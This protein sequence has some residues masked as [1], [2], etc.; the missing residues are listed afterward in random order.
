M[1]RPHPADWFDIIV[2][3]DDMVLLVEELARNACV[4][5]EADAGGPREPSRDL[6]EALSRFANLAQRF[7]AYWPV[8]EAVVRP[9]EIHDMVKRGLAGIE[10][11]AAAA[12]PVLE[13]LQSLEG[14]R[15]SLALW[16]EVLLEIEDGAL[17]FAQ[18]TAPGASVEGA[19]FVFPGEAAPALP[20]MVLG[21]RLRVGPD[22][23]V[24]AIGPPAG[25]AA[26]TQQA[27]S[28]QGKRVEIPRWLRGS[29]RQSL[30]FMLERMEAVDQAAVSARAE[31]AAIS[32]Q[33]RLGEGLGLLRHA[34]WM[35]RSIEVVASGEHFC[36]ITGW[37]DDRRRLAATMEASNARALVHFPD[38]PGG[39]QAP[40]LLRNPWWA[41]PFEVFSRALGMPARY[42]AD[43]SMLLALIVPLLFGYMFGDVGQGAVLIGAGL[44]LRNRIPVL[45]MLLAGGVSAMLF[46]LVFGSVF[47]M[48]GVLPTLW[49]RP[50][51]EPLPVLIVPLVGG[52]LL[53]VLGLAINALGAYWRGKFRHWLATDA[54]LIVVYLG[55]L[56][57]FLDARGYWIAALGAL[58]P[59]AGHLVITRRV[60]PALAAAGELLEKIVRLL[61]N[62]L[63]FVRVGAFALAHAGLSA[64]IIA[65]AE[66]ATSAPGYL[67][68][69]IV[70]NA[71]AIVVEAL[72]VSVQTTRLVLFEFFTRFFVSKGREYRPLPPPAF[73]RG[74]LHE[75]TI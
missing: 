25:L 65:L 71:I 17:D 13:T 20:S 49:V 52:G 62:T 32:A 6:Q 9:S 28:A 46:G 40:L 38:P 51:D 5:L 7:G 70:G 61:I 47:G 14:E 50:L 35:M 55:I 33:Y 23:A 45:G 53:L 2:A 26:F 36:R 42:A 11:W 41:R 74:E 18:L 57:G 63:S 3:K 43:P 15:S 10:A 67:I 22:S 4:E 64:A 66:G 21:R 75:S 54:G 8:A 58:L 31:L 29:V 60:K 68:V 27:T 12:G 16:H 19:L 48:E 59:V 69:M 30:A 37:T 24:L 73:V 72:V 1:I 39:V 56:G 34:E 44:L